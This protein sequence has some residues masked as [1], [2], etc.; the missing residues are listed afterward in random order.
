MSIRLR[1]MLFAAISTLLLAGVGAIGLYQM[2]VVK[3]LMLNGLEDSGKESETLIA[4]ETAHSSF[5]TQVQ[6]WKDTLLR[7]NDPESFEKYSA[8]F[9]K[10]AL[11]VQALLSQARE[12]M[13]TQRLD[14]AEVDELIRHHAELGNKYHEALKQYDQKN[15]HSAQVVDKLVKGMDRPTASGMGK[16]VAKIEQD[17]Q[18]KL[19]QREADGEA[20]FLLAR[21]V[22]VLLILLGI[23]IGIVSALGIIRILH[24]GLSA[25]LA[26]A[27]RL[28]TGDLTTQIAVSSK[29]EIGQLLLS[30]REMLESLAHIVGEVG[31]SAD[32]LSAASDEVS[33]TAHGISLVLNEQSANMSET[34]RSVEQT[35]GAVMRNS[36]N[37]RLTEDIAATAAREAN[38]GGA[39]VKETVAAMKSIAGKIAVIDD[40]AYQTNLLAL[41]AAIEAARAGEHGKG[42]SVVATE[43]RKLAERSQLAAQEIG[44]LASG[45][46]EKAERAGRLLEEIVPGINKTAGLVQEIAAS[47]KEQS[48]GIA[49]IDEAMA[50]LAQ[51]TEQNAHSSETLATTAEEVSAQAVRLQ[52]LMRFF[53]LGVRNASVAAGFRS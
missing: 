37:A 12:L 24:R 26:V 42:F 50:K 52:Q 38:D 18:V 11:H 32:V 1:L 41:N 51:S 47:S 6:E 8:A 31:N 29:D 49:H 13:V 9:D 22:F 2:S 36:E 48:S 17:M 53:T 21:N 43:V 15:P 40:I 33:A 46:V 3:N 20:R 34:T 23:A 39:A 30:M 16:L 4:V 7:G 27:K 28:A 45:S 5:K 25:A 10:E 44:A 14:T 35:S 19:K